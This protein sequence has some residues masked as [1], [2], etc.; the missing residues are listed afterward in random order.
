MTHFVGIY[1]DIT[2]HKQMERQLVQAQ[3]MQASAPW[4]EA[5]PT[6]STTCWRASRAMPRWRC[7]NRSCRPRAREFLEFIVQLSDR[8]ANLTRQ[9]LAFAR[10]PSLMRQS[11]GH[12]E[13]AGNHAQS[14]AAQPEYRGRAGDGHA[15]PT[16]RAAT[17]LADANQLQQV[18]VNLSLN[19]RDAMPK[20]QPAPVIFR[21]R[22][23]VLQRRAAGVSAECAAGRL[24]P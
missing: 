1:R 10:K 8:A 11:D 4:R 6:S 15:A 13:A 17:A 3:K 21:L 23:R 22:H 2:E 16:A 7:A 24:L 20:P 9:L 14:R 12:D 19:A 5:W 18:L